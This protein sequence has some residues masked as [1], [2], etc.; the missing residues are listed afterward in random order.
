MVP[1]SALHPP[2]TPSMGWVP[3][4]SLVLIQSCLVLLVILAML[5]HKVPTKPAYYLTH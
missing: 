5:L 2:S 1:L 3:P 4:S